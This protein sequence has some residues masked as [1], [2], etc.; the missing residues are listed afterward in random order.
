MRWK[1][2]V[3]GFLWSVVSIALV[4]VTQPTGRENWQFLPDHVCDRSE[5][6][7][8][9]KGKSL[10]LGKENTDKTVVLGESTGEKRIEVDLAAQKL[11]AFEGDTKVMEFFVSTGKP[12]TPTPKGD[13]RIWIKVRYAKMEGGQKG[14]KGYYYLPNVPFIM[15]FYNAEYPKAKGYA[16]HGAYWHWNFGQTMSHGCVNL[17]ISDAEKLYYWAMPDL[18]GKK[19]IYA[20]DDNPGTAIR[21]Y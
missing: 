6:T 10:A 21:I 4:W 5:Q 15:F 7:A 17:A 1:I 13:F 12:W 14:T 11:Y 19:S 2:G 16:L 18:M 20:T 8:V 9:W 3:V